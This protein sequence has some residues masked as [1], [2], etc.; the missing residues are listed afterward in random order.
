MGQLG[1]SPEVNSGGD[2]LT[3]RASSPDCGAATV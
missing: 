3:D 1:N 2:H